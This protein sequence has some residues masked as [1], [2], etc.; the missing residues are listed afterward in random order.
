MTPTP[1]PSGQAP[2]LEARA[3][4]R[5]FGRTE[6]LRGASLTIGREEVVAITG[7][8]GSGKSTL[9]MCLAGVIRPE[10]GEVW[11]D[12][13]R[14]DAMKEAERTRLRR[15]QVGIVLQFGQL[16]PDLTVLQNVALPLL[17]ERH[18]RRS[19]EQVATG[20]LE[21]LG[22]S[23]LALARPGELSGGEGQRVAIARALV[24]SPSVVL[25]DEPTGALDTLGSE[26]V[27]DALLL[28]TRE[29]GASL[30]LVTHDRS[31]AAVA[32]RE[33]IVRDGAVAEQIG[34][35]SAARTRSTGLGR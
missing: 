34:D 16:V 3:L 35:A 13:Q 11:F 14:L 17:L 28:A 29:S 18:D 19:A 26:Q 30:V 25:A 27:L 7:P 8:S 12:G 33:I 2:L 10:A 31:V 5:A 21:R 6:A 15:R 4:H 9:L 20:W 24:T 32:G 22:V 23:G 1:A